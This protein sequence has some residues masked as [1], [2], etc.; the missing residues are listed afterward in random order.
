MSHTS[1][2]TA[3][4]TTA[5]ASPRAS[6]DNTP[7]RPIPLP[8]HIPSTSHALATPPGC[9]YIQVNHLH[10][11]TPPG[12][13]A[14]LTTTPPHRASS[15]PPPIDFIV[16]DDLPPLQVTPPQRDPSPPP[17]S[18]N[19]TCHRCGHVRDIVYVCHRLNPPL[20]ERPLKQ[21]TFK[22]CENCLKQLINKSQHVLLPS[23]SAV[24]GWKQYYESR[25]DDDWCCPRCHLFCDCLK[26]MK[27]KLPERVTN[28]P[29]KPCRRKDKVHS[30][31]FDDCEIMETAPAAKVRRHERR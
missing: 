29:L 6:R 2:P 15:A 5:V 28:S 21:C 14:W 16:D 7:L 27:I 19:A 23:I 12:Y 26:C 3:Q 1:D 25:G 17:T 30:L 9:N 24:N 22:F 18:I 20:L 11:H 4:M 31:M 10:Y 8:F 13:T